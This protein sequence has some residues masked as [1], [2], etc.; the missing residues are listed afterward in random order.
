MRRIA[1]LALALL[2]AAAAFAADDTIRKGFNVPDGGTLHLD[3]GVGAIKVVA[4]GSGVAF[5]VIRHA[6]GRRGEEMLR[7]HAIKFEQRGND[8]YVESKWD[9]HWLH[10]FA[11]YDVQW[12]IRV[13]AHYNVDLQTS[14][15][16][17]DLADLGG[18]VNARTAGGA[19]KTGRL[20]GPANLKTSGGSITLAGARGNVVAYTSGGAINIGDTTGV[21]DART[22]GGSITIEHASGDIKAH[23]SGGGIRIEDAM[24][25]VDAHTSGGPIHARI[26]KQP[27][28]PSRLET[29]G[30][31]VTVEL[32]G[33]I[34]VD[35]DAHASG[36]G[37]QSDVP[38]TIQ[39]TQDEDSLEG[40]IN[41]GGPRLV[42]RSSGGGIRVRPM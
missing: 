36:G 25:S 37:V 6:Y 32:A 28:A 34:G 8:V 27:A 5:E 20:T 3:A 31:G 35:L 15:G 18:T 17:I 40:K 33:G 30:G 13:P 11:E 19:I 29:S 22:S 9:D 4:G 12:N 16:S 2:T 38:I 7:E 39:G 10:W 42:L 14:G 41:G 23:T 21:I 26:S 24:G 1:T